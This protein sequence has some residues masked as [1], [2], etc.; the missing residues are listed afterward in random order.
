[1]APEPVVSAEGVSFAF[2]IDPV[3]RDVS[4]EVSQR[5]FVA[6]VGPNG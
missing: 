2:G 4:F 1:V 3:L 6:L 5:E